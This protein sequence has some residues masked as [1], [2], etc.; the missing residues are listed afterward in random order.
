MRTTTRR[1]LVFG[2]SG[3]FA[4][5][6][7]FFFEE[8]KFKKEKPKTRLMQKFQDNPFPGDISI[9]A[10]LCPAFCINVLTCF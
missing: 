10:G 1:S 4:E 2:S 3:I 8:T 5:C 7:G 9:K 6:E